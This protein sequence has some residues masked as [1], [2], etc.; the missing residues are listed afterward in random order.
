MP[1]PSLVFF[2]IA[3]I[4]AIELSNGLAMSVLPGWHTTVITP[5]VTISL[6]MLAWLFVIPVGYF[7][8]ERK[9]KL[10]T[11]RQTVIHLFLTLSFFL[12]S[13]NLL[14]AV[15]NERV[16]TSMPLLLFVTGQIFFTSIFVRKVWWA[17]DEEKP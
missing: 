17:R 2:V 6:I 16:A 1:K 3:L 12:L 8:L 14:Y 9:N 10:P 5:M 13:N 4:P 15:T 11:N 7:I